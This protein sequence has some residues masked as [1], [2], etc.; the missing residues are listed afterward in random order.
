MRTDTQAPAPY[1]ADSYADDV[2]FSP[3]G[4]RLACG[5][6]DGIV[7][8]LDAATRKE[9]SILR[10]HLHEIAD[11]AFSPDGRQVAYAYDGHIWAVDTEG[12]EPRRLTEGG[13]PRWSPVLRDCVPES[14]PVVRTEAA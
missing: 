12:G 2:D 4:T 1:I 5:S 13:A 9:V 3:D 8:V 14:K 11:V 7:R 10:A 6:F